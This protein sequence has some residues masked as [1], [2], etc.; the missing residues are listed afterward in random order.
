MF[1]TRIVCEWCLLPIVYSM[2]TRG[3][4][5]LII[6]CFYSFLAH[7][8]LTFSYVRYFID[9]VMCF[10][11]VFFYQTRTTDDIISW[12]REIKLM[13]VKTSF[14]I[15]KRCLTSCVL[16]FMLQIMTS[17]S[18]PFLYL[19]YMYSITWCVSYYICHVMGDDNAYCENIDFPYYI[20]RQVIKEKKTRQEP[21]CETYN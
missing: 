4:Y 19:L 12:C 3:F 21:W 13:I 18:C 2:D 16:S 11:R 14:D 9:T 1:K 17:T 7:A 15:W 5:F 8:T 10:K 6:F 20:N